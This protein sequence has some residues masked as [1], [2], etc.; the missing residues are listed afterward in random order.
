MKD[1]YQQIKFIDTKLLPLFDISSV[2]DYKNKISINDLTNKSNFLDDMNKLLSDIKKY[3]PIKELNLH[4]TDGKIKSIL[5][6]FCLLKK[7]LLIANIPFVIKNI[8]KIN[9]LCLIKENNLLVNYIKKYKM[10]DIQENSQDTWKE[11]KMLTQKDLME[12]I[13]NIN[14]T[15]IYLYQLENFIIF[16]K[17]INRYVISINDQYLWHKNFNSL[18]INYTKSIDEEYLEN[19]FNQSIINIY[20]GKILLLTKE[21][22]LNE[23]IIDNLIFPFKSS[24]PFTNII[25]EIISESDLRLLKNITLSVNIHE[26]EFYKHIN[27]QIVKN[28]NIKLDSYA[29]INKEIILTEFIGYNEIEKARQIKNDYENEGEIINTNPIG[30]K[31]KGTFTDQFILSNKCIHAL[32]AKV[33]NG[34]VIGQFKQK[35]NVKYYEKNGNKIIIKHFLENKCDAMQKII[36]KFPENKLKSIKIM[37][38]FMPLYFD[39]NDCVIE[40]NIIEYSDKVIINPSGDFF[41]LINPMYIYLK[42]EFDNLDD[43]IMELQENI[44]IITD[45]MYFD[46]KDRKDLVSYHKINF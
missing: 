21:F 3:F 25:L 16:R 12:G 29:I 27:D 8:N 6:A 40:S 26:I 24:I 32:I 11:I 36:L 1:K 41:N 38:K 45:D 23:N 30:Y 17:D 4:K 13:K 5:Q 22:K 46:Y 19:I 35:L 9:Y 7:L 37:G 39:T 44:E 33:P 34:Y 28:M 42:L 14:E 2:I 43:N 31:F 20:A 18:K 10:S 15:K